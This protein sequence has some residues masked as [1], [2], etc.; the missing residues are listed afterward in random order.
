[1]ATLIY[2]CHTQGRISSQEMLS[3]LDILSR[4]LDQR[5]EELSALLLRWARTGVSDEDGG[6]INEIIKAT[7]VHTDWKDAASRNM[8]IK[9]VRDLVT[10]LERTIK[11][12]RGDSPYT[13]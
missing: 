4:V 5:D 2:E 1:L 6:E 8:T 7:L 3:L 10:E 12:R 9:L 13:G 11:I